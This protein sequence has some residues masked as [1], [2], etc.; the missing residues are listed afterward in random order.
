VLKESMTPFKVL[1]ALCIKENVHNLVCELVRFQWNHVTKMARWLL[2]I[3]II[4]NVL[5]TFML[6]F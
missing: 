1:H 3:T 5:K 2:L 6:G 4:S